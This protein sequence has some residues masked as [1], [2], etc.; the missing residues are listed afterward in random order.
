MEYRFNG[1]EY[2]NL[3]NII[4]LCGVVFQEKNPGDKRSVLKQYIEK[5]SEKNKALILEENFVFGKTNKGKLS[6]DHIYM[7]DLCAV[8]SLASLFAD[9]VFI[10]H[11]SISTGTELGIFAS[12]PD[13]KQKVC[14]LVPDEFSVEEK[15]ITNFIRLAFLKGNDK[16]DII[17]Y[18]PKRRSKK[19]SDNKIDIIT[20]F[21]DNRVGDNLLQKVN[22]FIDKKS[23]HTNKIEFRKIRFGQ[24]SMQ[25]S[26]IEYSFQSNVDQLSIFMPPSIMLT[27]LISLFSIDDF[28][29]KIRKEKNISEHVSDIEKF[30]QRTFFNTLQC[31]EGNNFS[32]IKINVKNTSISFRDSIAF[33]IYLLQAMQ[34]IALE[35]D[36]QDE[37][38][39]RIVISTELLAD[40][41]RYEHLISKLSPT[42]FQGVLDEFI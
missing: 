20:S 42:K 11:E 9:C 12:N 3:Y 22:E 19:I 14:L 2:D 30:F 32:N 24:T 27:L 4:F 26:C 33:S 23:T 18:Y 41:K 16:V 17:T 8:E 13:I 35:Q 21:L 29:K 39:R 31:I 10:I 25:S 7:K 38:K 1:G 36:G 34:L 5:L 40:S 28:K 37:E 15:K 6:Y